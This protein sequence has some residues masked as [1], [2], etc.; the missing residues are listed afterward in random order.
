MKRLYKVCEAHP[1]SAQHDSKYPNAHPATSGDHAPQRWASMLLHW[2]TPAPFKLAAKGKRARNESH[3]CLAL[4]YTLCVLFTV[5]PAALRAVTCSPRRCTLSALSSKCAQLQ[6][7]SHLRTLFFPFLLM[8]QQVAQALPL[9]LLLLSKR[10]AKMPQHATRIAQH[11]LRNTTR[12][13][14][15]ASAKSEGARK[16]RQGECSEICDGGLKEKERGR[17]GGESRGGVHGG[18]MDAAH[19]ARAQQ[20]S[21]Q[22]QRSHRAQKGKGPER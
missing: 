6:R 20:R 16:A 4:L 1:S 17:R 14:A 10:K 18:E 8:L 22:A 5:Q 9:Y 21:E 2:K 15:A 19:L 11:A 7:A 13:D 12:Q 3:D